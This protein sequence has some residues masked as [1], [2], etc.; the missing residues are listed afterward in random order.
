M[1]LAPH[2]VNRV[3]ELV[4]GAAIDVHAALGP[5]LLESTYQHCLRRE[6]Q[7]RGIAFAAEV[8]VPITYRGEGLDCGY[9]LDLVVEDSLIVEIKSVEKLMPIHDA[10]LLTYLRLTRITAGL[11]INF[12]VTQLRFGLRRLNLRPSSP[13]SPLLVNHRASAPNS[14]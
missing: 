10:Q 6:L 12:N 14:G 8:N 9:R 7:F 1:P 13:T 4:I 2:P 5:G 3:S 11:V